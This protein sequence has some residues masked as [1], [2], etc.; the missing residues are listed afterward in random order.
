MLL[1]G[2]KPDIEGETYFAFHVPMRI[3]NDLA[4]HALGA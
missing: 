2:M 1:V 3:G 4:G